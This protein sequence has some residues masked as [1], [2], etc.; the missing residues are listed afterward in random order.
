MLTVKYY[1]SIIQKRLNSYAQAKVELITLTSRVNK[2]IGVFS[3]R[4][5]RSKM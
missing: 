1:Y 5:E 4:P 2:T 3:V